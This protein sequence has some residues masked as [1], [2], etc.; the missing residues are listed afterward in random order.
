MIVRCSGR[1]PTVHRLTTA[2]HSERYGRAGPRS[3]PKPRP[4]QGRSDS[5]PALACIATWPTTPYVEKS[6]A[7]GIELKEAKDASALQRIERSLA[8]DELVVAH[9]AIGER[10]RV[11]SLGREP[12]ASGNSRTSDDGIEEVAFEAEMRRHGSI[13]EGAREARRSR[14]VLSS[15]ASGS[16]HAGFRSE[17]QWPQEAHRRGWRRGT[18]CQEHF[19]SARRGALRSMEDVVHAGGVHRA[20]GRIGCPAVRDGGCQ[21]L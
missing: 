14:S 20:R 6:L 5:T 11:P 7:L 10:D 15:R 12:C 1:V 21:G 17:R 9:A 19:K 2:G 3:C 4:G 8:A 18:A 13:V 16:C